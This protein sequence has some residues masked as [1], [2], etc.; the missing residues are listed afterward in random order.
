[1]KHWGATASYRKTSRRSTSSQAADI[2]DSAVVAATLVAIWAL[3][4]AAH[5]TWRSWGEPEDRRY[6][7]RRAC[8]KPYFR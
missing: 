4:L 7:V 6:N 8:N 5:I 2:V 3:R 1:V